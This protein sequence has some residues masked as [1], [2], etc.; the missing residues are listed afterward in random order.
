MGVYG[1]M[2][3]GLTKMEALAKYNI[4]EVIYDANID[5]VLNNREPSKE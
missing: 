2:R 1:A 5:C 3:R 4:P